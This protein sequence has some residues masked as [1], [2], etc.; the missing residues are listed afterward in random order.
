M[1]IDL[2]IDPLPI[3]F[4]SQ[5]GHGDNLSILDDQADFWTEVAAVGHIRNSRIDQFHAVGYRK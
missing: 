3:L 1:Q 2:C 4:S 5:T